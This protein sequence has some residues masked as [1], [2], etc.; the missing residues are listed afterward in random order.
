MRQRIIKSKN[1]LRHV[2]AA[3]V[4][5]LLGATGAIAQNGGEA[6]AGKAAV[7]DA[8]K[9]GA[10][11]ARA[12]E[13]VKAA[14]ALNGPAGNPECVLVGK[15]V[16]FLVWRED[17]A[18]ALRQHELYDRFGCPGNHIPQVLRCLTRFTDKIDDK[19]PDSLKNQISDCWINPAAQPESANVTQTPQTPPNGMAASQPPATPPAAPPAAK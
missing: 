7:S 12:D 8:K 4:V 2:A 17:P 9:Q 14:Q 13:Y 6:D 10:G 5:I 19:V 1:V 15:K 3:A 11:T 16:V 18:T